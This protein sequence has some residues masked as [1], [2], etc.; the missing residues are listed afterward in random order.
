MRRQEA[1]LGLRETF[2]VVMENKI[3][4]I[5]SGIDLGDKA[6]SL[7]VGDMIK[8]SLSTR[9][10]CKILAFYCSFPKPLPLATFCRCK[11]FR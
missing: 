9:L 3:P 5:N 8:C 1:A 10:S 4:C 2:A 6:H 7:R 11:R